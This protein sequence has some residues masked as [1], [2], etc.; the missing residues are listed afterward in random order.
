MGA[1]R[2]AFVIGRNPH[3]DLFPLHRKG[4]GNLTGSTQMF[5]NKILLA[6]DL[7]EKSH[8]AEKT[9][10]ALAKRLGA[11]LVILHVV[12]Q[13]SSFGISTIPPELA[14]AEGASIRLQTLG[15]FEASDATRRLERGSPAET[16][17]RVAKEEQ[18][19]LVVVGAHGRK[20]LSRTVLG[21]VAEAFTRQSTC[22]V[23]VV[24]ADVEIQSG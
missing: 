15:E 10:F 1:C 12:P 6:S 23:V 11:K 5:P 17:L 24:K 7:T 9:A 20:R 22:P 18:V 2:V 16:I 3:P 8:A 13:R 14:D 4:R 19:D 21:S